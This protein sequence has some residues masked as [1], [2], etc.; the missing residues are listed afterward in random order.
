MNAQRVMGVDPGN[1]SG[2]ATQYFDENAHPVGQFDAYELHTYQAMDMI[3]RMGSDYRTSLTI[4]YEKY[5]VNTDTSRDY[6]PLYVV[7]VIEY[8]G[9]YDGVTVLRPQHPT[10]RDIVSDKQLDVIGWL[11]PSKDGH[12]KDAAKHLTVA[13]RRLGYLT[14][15]LKFK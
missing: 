6:E 12:M 15:D 5:D 4:V 11:K 9:Q 8:V 2:L 13:C 10:Q 7:G 14:S 1:V 3:L